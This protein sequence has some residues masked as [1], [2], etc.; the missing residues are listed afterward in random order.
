MT[1]APIIITADEINCLIYSYFQ[2]SGFNHSAFALRNEGRLQNSPYF[3]KHIPRGELIDLLSKAL[4]Y[5]EVESHWRTDSLTTNCKA[6]FSLLDPH[7]CS[8]DDPS[9]KSPPPSEMNMETV[10]SEKLPVSA[11]RPTAS[12]APAPTPSYATSQTKIPLPTRSGLPRP[13]ESTISKEA[14][15]LPEQPKLQSPTPDSAAADGNAKRKTS[16]VPIDGHVEKRAR[17]MS[18]DMDI[19]GTSDSARSKSPGTRDMSVYSQPDATKVAKVEMRSRGPGDFVTDPRVVLLLPGHQTEVFVCAFNPKM[20]NLLASG[21]KDGVVNVW[22]LPN[23]PPATSPDFAEAPE[24]PI[25]LE[26]V[27]N[28]SQGDLTSLDWNFDGTLLAIG[29]YDSILRVC[30]S[31]GAL[32]FS[33]PQHQGPIFAT[34][35][36]RNG[37]WL[38]TAS[39]DGTTCLWDVKEKRLHKQYRCHKGGYCCLDVE[40]LDEDTF[41]SAGA[42]MRIFIM[43]VDEDESIKTLI[44]HKDEINQIRVNPSG[45]RLASCS[46]DGTACIWKVDNIGKG[47]DNIPGLSASEQGVMLKGHNH[48]VSTVGWSKDHPAGTNELLATSS[49]DGTARL[50]DSV[51]GECLHIFKDHKGPLYSLTFSPNGK[52]VATGSG[53]GWLYIY[54]IRSRERVWSWFAGSGKPGV[55]EIDWQDHEGINRIAM[56]LECRQVAVVDVAKLDLLRTLQN[57][58]RTTAR[59]ENVPI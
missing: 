52:F 7:I 22:N 39:L 23:P 12:S 47:V 40:W 56:A 18:T 49:F 37:T 42:D 6:G 21:S 5:L 38:L 4:L 1:A 50:W 57:G 30:T 20:P 59:I 33:H 34:R 44:G 43:R 53:D 31:S 24:D 15:T 35:F 45:T 8:L 11:Q 54:H 19:D 28:F 26:N 58:I 32:H 14:T 3:Q 13:L 51:T 16:P 36:S 48:S 46:D 2:D 41:A 27:S 10:D 9:E 25:A 55:F 17:H 29:S